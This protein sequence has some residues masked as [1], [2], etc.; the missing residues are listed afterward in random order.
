MEKYEKYYHDVK[1]FISPLHFELNPDETFMKLLGDAGFQK[2]TVEV[3]NKVYEYKD[4]NLLKG[5]EVCPVLLRNSQ[6]FSSFSIKKSGKFSWLEI[7]DFGKNSYLKSDPSFIQEISN[8][9]FQL[10]S[11]P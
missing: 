7:Q 2:F 6:N 3:R 8:F 1:K 4:E 11:K 10:Q 5:E 9:K